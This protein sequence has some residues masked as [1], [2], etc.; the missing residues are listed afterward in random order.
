MGNTVTT[1]ELVDQIDAVAARKD[2]LMEG[3]TQ[4]QKTWHPQAGRWSILDCL[5]H[6]NRSDALYLR[7]MRVVFERDRHN[8]S[9]PPKMFRLGFIARQMIRYLE[10]PPR[11]RMPAPQSIMP[12]AGLRPLEVESEFNRLHLELRGFVIEA[13]RVNMGAIHFA[14]PISS[15]LKISLAEGCSILCAHDRRHLWQ[16]EQIRSHRDF[17]QA[18]E[19]TES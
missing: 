9:L 8:A 6:L 11:F 13:G 1:T 18:G 14:S 19:V 16:A 5:E 2:S 4:E 12:P 17:P 7:A 10:P 3:L 15:L